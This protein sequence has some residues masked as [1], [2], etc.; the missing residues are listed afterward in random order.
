VLATACARRPEVEAIEVDPLPLYP[1]SPYLYMQFMEPLGTTDGSVE[2]AWDHRRKDWREDL[3]AVTRDLAPAM[4]RWGGIFTNYYRWREG[5]GPRERRPFMRN[6]LWGGWESNQVGTAEFVSLCRKVSAEPLIAVNFESDG[7]R[8]FTEADGSVRTAG[9]EEAAAW[10][11][12]CNQPNHPERVAHGNPEPFNVRFWQI[13]NETSY[14][15]NGFDLATAARKTAEFARAMRQADPTIELIGWG[16]DGGGLKGRLLAHW[17]KGMMEAAGEH[18]Q[19]LAFHHMFNPD[20]RTRPVLAWNEFR[21]DPARTWEQLMG[22]WRIHED[23]IRRMRER[24]RPYGV[25]LAM[26][27]CHFAIPGR[28]RC[29]VLSTWAAGVSYARLL[30]VHERHGDVLKIA[31]AA[32]FCGSRWQV[33]A[34]MIP[35]PGGKSFLMPVAHVM[36][37]YRRYSGTEAVGVSRAPADLDVTASRGGERL[38]LH[39]VNTNMRGAVRTRLI[40]TGRRIRSGRVLEISADPMFEE[41][42]SEPDVLA[43]KERQLGPQGEWTFPAASVSAVELELAAA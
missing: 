2:A 3:V 25:A 11:A 5:V 16:E 43:V 31:T 7:R 8:Q 21:K 38:W 4:I 32:D 17:A 29:E 35:V 15:P 28:N 22:A 14:D 40:V 18:L 9:A 42:G 37:L 24:V 6:L 30:H 39:V 10:V 13:G 36:R 23:K 19:Y 20:S 34:V 33:N 1:L 41:M 27:E 12:Y 26:T